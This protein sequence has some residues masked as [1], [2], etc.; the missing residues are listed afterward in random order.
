V[1]KPDVSLA[2][3]SS[4]SFRFFPY[5]GVSL[6]SLFTATFAAFSAR[7]FCIMA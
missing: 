1:E 7:M 3:S 4:P 6:G 5:N 2:S